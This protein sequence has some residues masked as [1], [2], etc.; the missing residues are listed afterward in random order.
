MSAVIEKID[1]RRQRSIS[2][3]KQLIQA[4]LTVIAEQ[5]LAGCTL[6]TVS[7]ESGLSRSS[8]GFHFKS[9]DQMLAETLQYL[10]N[11]YRQGWLDISAQEP[12]SAADKLIAMIKWELGPIACTSKKVAAWF[13]FWGEVS[14][15]PIYRRLVSQSDEQYHQI[16]KSLIFEISKNQ[17]RAESIAMGLSSMLIGL[18]MHYH[19][20][21]QSY[22]RDRAIQTCIDYLK[23]PFPDYFD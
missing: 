6:S 13:A 9:K 16:I 15:R 22:D 11:E 10:L 17:Q 4:T 3:R 1:L 2:S 8:V 23:S 12:L 14:V 20:D 21:Q 5:G 18:W 19:I 7:R